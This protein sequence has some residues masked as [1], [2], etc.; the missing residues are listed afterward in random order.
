MLTL[1]TIIYFPSWKVVVG[2]H[3]IENVGTLEQMVNVDTII[4][5]P[6]WDPAQV[7]Y[8]IALL[9]LATPLTLNDEVQ[10]ICL[11]SDDD[12]QPGDF[13]WATGWGWVEGR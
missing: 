10:P 11:S 12:V 8:D 3:D 5:H 2:D 6:D 9:H 4:I 7:R 1:C 13:C